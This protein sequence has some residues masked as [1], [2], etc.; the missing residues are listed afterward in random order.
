MIWGRGH[1]PGDFLRVDDRT[2]FVRWASETRK[3]WT[4]AIVHRNKFEARHPQDF[5]RGKRDEQRVPDP[6]SRPADQFQL[7]SDGPFFFVTGDGSNTHS[8]EVTSGDF[9]VYT[10]VASASAASL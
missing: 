2:G 6:R 8:I 1:R 7:A 5:V 4:G 9:S 10:G 3:E